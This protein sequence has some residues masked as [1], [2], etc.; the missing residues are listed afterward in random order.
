MSPGF[1][2]FETTKDD[3]V[4]AWQGGATRRE[5]RTHVLA[6]DGLLKILGTEVGKNLNV[7]TKTRTKLWLFFLFKYYPY[8]LA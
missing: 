4:P 2:N 7:G 6:K 5:G 3:N 1:L 8:R